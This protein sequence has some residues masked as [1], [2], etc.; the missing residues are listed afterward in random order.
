M[1]YIRGCSGLLGGKTEGDGK[2]EIGKTELDEI[3]DPIKASFPIHFTPCPASRITS[4]RFFH[5]IS[6]R[7]SLVPGLDFPMSTCFCQYV[8][9]SYIFK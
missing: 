6:L 8:Y 1:L 4:G 7:P 9:S 3:Y 5:L 2:T